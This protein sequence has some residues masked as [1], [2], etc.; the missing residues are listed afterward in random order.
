MSGSSRLGGK[1]FLGNWM[2][3]QTEARIETRDAIVFDVIS[4]G[5]CRVKIQGS[6]EP[7]VVY[8]QLG[9]ESA[10]NYVTPGQSVRVNHRGGIRGLTE[11]VSI[12]QTVPTTM[13]GGTAPTI[14]TGADA[15]L[16]GCQLIAI[17]EIEL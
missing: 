7:I 4:A 8:Y 1:R 3:A 6:D 13:P 11:I 5:I 15:I 16:T 17:P 14:G 9:R 12:G 2:A 10:P